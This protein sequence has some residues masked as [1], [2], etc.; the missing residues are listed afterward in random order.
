MHS[1]YFKL[2]P[3]LAAALLAGAPWHA[4]AQGKVAGLVANAGVGDA[5]NRPALMVRDP[6]KAFLL[7][8][9]RAGKRLVAVGER[10]VI[11]L[12]DD[13][14]RSWRQASVPVSVTLTAVRFSSAQQGWAVGHSGVVLHSA[15]GGA[16]W[17]R[18]LDGVQAA[19]LALQ[20]AEAR[21][22]DIIKLGEAQR[23]VK[24]GA[25]KPLLGL[26]FSDDLHGIVV[27]AYNL[28]FQTADGGKT[29]TP[30]LERLDNPKA[31]HLYAVA[32]D[33]NIMYIA[34]EQGTLLRS[35]DGG[36]NFERLASPY[37]G[38]LFG[39][40]LLPSGDVVLAG[41]RGNA[42]RSAD[43]GVSWTRLEGVPP[44][45]FTS[46]AS[47]GAGN[48]MLASQ[49]G[50]LYSSDAGSNAL[51]L[52]PGP[53]LPPLHDACLLPDGVIVAVSMF[54]AIRIPATRGSL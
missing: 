48:A 38:S 3:L 24:D 52:L 34:G 27:G 28:A 19:R 39:V 50:H 32:A 1:R 37:K 30:L 35:V 20:S 46:V 15:D 29:W 16:T 53:A 14:G 21:P 44:V 4:H 2:I 33:A 45:S 17:S 47:T 22:D 54:G 8:L 5:L 43:R 25:D 41:L 10:G 51:R 23:L 26:H 13:D 9:T 6:A 18:Q 31:F 36:R 11:V 40:A 12:S 49:S 7:G 42:Y